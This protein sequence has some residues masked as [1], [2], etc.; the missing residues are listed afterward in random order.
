MPTRHDPVDKKILEICAKFKPQPRV[1]RD[2][3][4]GHLPKFQL[5]KE[6]AEGRD[7]PHGGVTVYET[8]PPLL[9]S[10]KEKY[11]KHT[12]LGNS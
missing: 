4:P 9:K 6:E 1:D 3:E 8:L 5:T 11:T 7:K 12:T 2:L 10:E